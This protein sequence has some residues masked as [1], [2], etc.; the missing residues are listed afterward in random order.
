MYFWVLL[1]KLALDIPSIFAA[2]A[3]F[4]LLFS[5]VVLIRLRSLSES[6]IVW[7]LQGVPAKGGVEDMEPMLAGRS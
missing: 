6:V 2:L 7:G 5:S 1:Y 4:H 3:I